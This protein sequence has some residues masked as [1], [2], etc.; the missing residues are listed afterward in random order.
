ME[1]DEMTRIRQSSTSA[2]VI[3]LSFL[4][5]FPV[6]FR[7]ES[8]WYTNALRAAL[9]GAPPCSSQLELW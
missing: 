7:Y 6:C 1:K 8:I 2:N 5:Y 4:L 3:L 9:S